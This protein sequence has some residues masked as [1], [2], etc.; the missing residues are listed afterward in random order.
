MAKKKRTGDETLTVTV[1]FHAVH[2]PGQNQRIAT[3]CAQARAVHNRVVAHL[4]AYRSDEPLHKSSSRSIIGIYGLLTRW[5]AEDDALRRIPLLIARGAAAAAADQVAKWE[6]ANQEQAVAVARAI[7]KGEQ[8]PRRA[9]RRSPDAKSLY[10]SRKREERDGRHRCRVDEKVRR[11]D[12][13]TLQVPGIGTIRTKDPIPDDVDV[14]SAVV[15]ERT[16]EARLGRTPEAEERTFKVHLSGRVPKPPL[17][18]PDGVGRSCGIDHGVV[19]DMTVVD[20]AGE[21]EAFDHD[22][23]ADKLGTRIRTLQAR[24]ARC[25][26]GSRKWKRRKKAVRRLYDRAAAKRRHQR[27][28]WANRICRHHDTVCTEKLAVRNMTGAARGTSEKCGRNVRAKRGLNRALLRVAPAEMNAALVRVGA[29]VGARVELVAAAGS[30]ITCNACAY[31]DP[32]NRESQADFRCRRCGHNDNADT[33]AA[34]NLRCRG[35]AAIRARM[36]ASQED[37]IH[38]PEEADAGRKN[39][40]LEQS[41]RHVAPDPPERAAERPRSRLQH[42]ERDRPAHKSWP[43]TESQESWPDGQYS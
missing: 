9:Q 37:G 39:G 29:R 19:H 38:P 43:E 26:T 22:V 32:K 6:A 25:R 18:T 20:D 1:R 15:L 40:R 31:R 13:H 21:V 10:R 2:D 35:V 30:S 36:D 11:G 4:L 3:A 17:R 41:R 12:R 8:I 23:K 28:S 14:R 24:A 7:D 27:R 5:R 42:S 33:N 34:R 16:P